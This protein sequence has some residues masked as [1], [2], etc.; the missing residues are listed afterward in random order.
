MTTN[1]ELFQQI[2]GGRPTPEQ[3][4]M[5]MNMAQGDTS[6]FMLEDGVPAAE[7]DP[8]TAQPTATAAP[9][10]KTEP[11]LNADNAVV[12]AKDGV[13]T[14][15]FERLTEARQTAQRLQAEAA[16]KDARIAEL[17]TLAAQR[18]EQGVSPTQQ[19][20]NLALAQAAIKQG[21]DPDLF[22]DFSEE[23]LVTG[24]D[25]LMDM[26]LEQRLGAFQAQVMAPIQQ[27][28]QA[29]AANL[30]L[31]AIYQ[32]HPDADSIVE[33]K[34]FSAWVATRPAYERASIAKVLD[35]GSSGDVVELFSAFKGATGQVQPSAEAAKAAAQAALDK[36]KAPPPASLSDIPGGKPVAGSRFEAI[37]QMEGAGMSDA[38]RGLTNEQIEA[39][40]NSNM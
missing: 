21:V 31:Q 30:H 36:S 22:G 11:E 29:E 19:D 27:Q 40:L 39:F 16:A 5:L 32:A 33:S 38:L 24:I 37:A 17:E 4:A 10:P 35:D 13:H 34:E 7:P 12:L 9:D 6:N 26:K 2:D 18:A 14:I 1:T 8:T 20:Q 23:A 3:A 25:K 28:R 15:P